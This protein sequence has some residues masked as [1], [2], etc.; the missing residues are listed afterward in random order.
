MQNFKSADNFLYET[1]CG[2]TNRNEIFPAS[3]VIG[4]AKARPVKI[5]PLWRVGT[6]CPAS[7]RSGFLGSCPGKVRTSTLHNLHVHSVRLN[8]FHNK[9]P[10]ELI[11]IFRKRAGYGSVVTSEAVPPLT[12]TQVRTTTLYNLHVH[13]VRLDY[14]HNKLP[15]ELIH[16]FR[17]RAGYGSVVTSEAVP[18]LT[19]T[20]VRTTTLYNLHVHSVRLD[21][22]HNKLPTEL[23]HIFRKRAGYGSVVTSEA[24]PPLTHTQ[25]RTTTLYNLHVH[26]VRLDYFHNKLPTELIHIFRKRAGYGS[27]VTS[28]AVPPLTHTQ[29]WTTTLYNLHVHSVR[30]DYFHNKLPTELIHIFRKRAGYGSVVTSEAVP[31]L[32][33]TQVRTTT[34][35]NLHVHSVRLDYFHNKL[36]TE[37]IHIFRK[38]AGYGSVVTSEAVPPLT[39]TQVRTTTLYNL[40]VHSV[41]LDYFHNKLPTELIHIFRKRAGYGSVVTSEAVPPLTHTQV[42]TTTLHNLHVHSVRLDYFHNKLPTELIHIFRKRAGYGSVVTSE[43]VPPL[44]HTQVWTTTLY[45]LHVHSV[46][47]DYF[48]NK[49]PTELIHI[50]RKRA[51]YGSVVTSEAVP[52]LTH[53]QVRTTTL[54]NLHVHS[55]RLDY[56]HNKLPTELIHIFRKRAGYGSVVTSEAVPP[57]TPQVRTTTLYNLHVHSV[58]LDYF[59]NKLPTE[60][61]HIFRKRAG[62]GSV[63]TSE[64]EPPLTHTQVRT[65]TLYNLHVHSVRLDYF[66]NKLPTELIHIFRKRAGYGS[67]V[68]SEAVPPLTHTQVWTTTLY[69]LHV[70]SVRLDYFHNKLPTELIHIFRKRAG[71]GSVVTSEAVPPLTH[72]Q[73]WTT[74]LH[75]LHVHSVRL[76]YFHNK[77][78]TELIHIF[79][80]RAGYGSVAGWLA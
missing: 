61:I 11:H 4:F 49:L 26:S 38:R 32:T 18:P 57:L 46:R 20:Q 25:V 12:H 5:H 10:T 52:P 55:V 78:P 36:P 75:N 53:T 80:K 30:L 73:V 29:V 27:V 74:T 47:L 1:L 39:H 62:Y 66:H 59:H 2:Q 77:L 34:L 43:A 63:V 37:L 33:H 19:H 8:Y 42:R 17:K 7:E 22:F 76:D 60:L 15:T 70:H 16:I 21:Y 56:F 14:F 51:G 64:A 40:H 67:V 58:R 13:S 69:N 45:N 35:Y 68:T 50:F 9:F 28:E 31:P 54:Y 3:R 65:T 41:R 79:R 71:Y 44:T 48:H 72:T 24:V 23:I 6:D